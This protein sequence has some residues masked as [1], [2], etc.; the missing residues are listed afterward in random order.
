MG[1]RSAACFTVYHTSGKEK[2]IVEL[3]QGYG[4]VNESRDLI[5]EEDVRNGASF[6]NDEV[7]IG[8]LGEVGPDLERMGVSYRG[9]QDAKYEFDGT[10]R[11][12]TPEL[13][14]EEFT[15]NNDGS[16][17]VYASDVTKITEK[18]SK[19]CEAGAEGS[20]SVTIGDIGACII[21]LNKMTGRAYIDAFKALDAL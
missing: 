5:E 6:V 2:A 19:L 12:F 13:G 16:M 21:E 9:A 20:W 7:S 18:L 10:V 1:D 11:Y 4:F 3:F 15:G 17:L 8:I 14:S